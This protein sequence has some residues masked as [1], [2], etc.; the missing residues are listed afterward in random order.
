MEQITSVDR[1][2]RK[3]KRY[4]TYSDKDCAK[5]GKYAAENGN[6]A[7]LKRY[8]SEHADLVESTVRSFSTL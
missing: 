7:I 6:V 4:A 5:I 8:I 3:R 2:E 1:S